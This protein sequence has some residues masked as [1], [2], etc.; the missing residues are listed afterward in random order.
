MDKAVSIIIVTWNNLEYTKLCI[1]SINRYT[2]HP[3]RFIFVDNGSSDKTPQYLSKIEN[4]VVIKNSTN[5][6]YSKAVNQG[7]EKVDSE[8]FC[9]LNNDIIV[10]E[11]WLENLVRIFESNK[12]LEQLTTNS[13]TIIDKTTPFNGVSFDNWIDFKNSHLKWDPQRLF[14]NYYK[15]NYDTFVKKVSQRFKGVMEIHESPPWFLGGWCVFMRSSVLKKIG[16]FLYDERFKMAF[17]EDVDL[18]WRTGL[19]GGKIGVAKEIYLHHFINTSA[20]KLK[21]PAQKLSSRNMEVFMEKWESFILDFLKKKSGKKKE[22]LK[23]YVRIDSVLVRFVNY[24][25][26]KSIIEDW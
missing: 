24:Y 12:A 1:E 5:V 17:W 25:G 19:A 7:M 23:D 18:S 4:T 9:L 6:G 14:E 13:N 20:T 3:Y 22:K 11:G 21:V 8:Y 10:S 15:N 26:G 2:K 16:G